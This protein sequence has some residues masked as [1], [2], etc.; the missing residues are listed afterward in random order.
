[1]K[2]SK[3]LA[4]EE[5]DPAILSYSYTLVYV[6]ICFFSPYI[7]FGPKRIKIINTIYIFQA[8]GN[9]PDA[10]KVTNPAADGSENTPA[11]VVIV[12]NNTEGATDANDKT[13]KA[14]DNLPETE[15]VKDGNAGGEDE[16]AEEPIDMSFPRGGDWKKIV[17]YLISAPIMFPLYYTLPDT[18]KPKRKQYILTHNMLL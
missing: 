15:V 11:A 5:I 18:K 3:I 12:E 4:C 8:T 13:K 10:P 16:D 6:M 1:M 14:D 9:D 7:D 17:L 2:K